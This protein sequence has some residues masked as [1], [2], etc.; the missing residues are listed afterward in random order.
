MAALSLMVE[1]YDQK[2]DRVAPVDRVA[3]APLV[4]TLHFDRSAAVSTNGK[5]LSPGKSWAIPGR[6]DLYALTSYEGEGF[7][8]LVRLIPLYYL[9]YI[10][11]I[12]INVY[13]CILY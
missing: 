3:N 12:I 8:P 2:V 10:I 6:L 4:P 1:R 5:S 7:C 13:L 9:V 11:Y